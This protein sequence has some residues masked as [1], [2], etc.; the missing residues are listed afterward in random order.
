MK[1]SLNSGA[2]KFL[3]HHKWS[4]HVSPF[5][6]ADIPLSCSSSPTLS[7][8]FVTTLDYEWDVIRGRR[9]YRWTIWVSSPGRFFCR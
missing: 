9:P 1:L 7:W 5:R 3:A 4:L 2:Q 8:E 6:Q